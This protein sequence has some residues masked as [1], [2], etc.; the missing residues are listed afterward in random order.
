[1]KR[2]EN[3][4]IIITGA[5]SG[6]GEAAALLFAKEGACVVVADFDEKG[7]NEMVQKIK[8]SGGEATFVKTDVSDTD[9]VQQMVAKQLKFMA[10]WMPLS[11][12][13]VWGEPLLL[14][15][16]FPKIYMTVPL[17]SIKKVSFY[18]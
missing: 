3:K 5:A 12:M 15:M 4:I 13:P 14:F 7:G 18:A 6:I 8:K 17:L 2:L 10:A 11:T 1:M 16:N 9:S